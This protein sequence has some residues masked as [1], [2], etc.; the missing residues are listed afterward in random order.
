MESVEPQINGFY[1]SILSRAW[2]RQRGI[3]GDMAAQHAVIAMQIPELHPSPG[4]F[5]LMRPGGRALSFLAST[6]INVLVMFRFVLILRL[7]LA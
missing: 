5:E 3:S 2:D 7:F 6:I 4:M 1:A